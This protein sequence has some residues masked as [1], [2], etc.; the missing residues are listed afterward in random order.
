MS[1]K[2]AT[3]IVSGLVAVILLLGSSCRAMAAPPADADLQN[4]AWFESLEQPGER[5]L[6]CC[7]IVDCHLTASRTS[8]D[9]YEVAIENSWTF[10]PIAF[11]RM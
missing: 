4:H 5:H 11:C 8:Q 7:S 2:A 1:S 6:L 9:G 10:P 3:C